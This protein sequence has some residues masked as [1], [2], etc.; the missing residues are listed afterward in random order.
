MQFNK[1][2]VLFKLKMPRT[3][4][5]RKI[6]HEPSTHEIFVCLS[7][8]P[9][10]SKLLVEKKPD[11]AY[12]EFLKWLIAIDFNKD[13]NEKTIL[14]KLAADFKIDTAKAIKW[15]KEI[16][17][18]IFELN[19]EMPVL[20]QKEGIKVC[21][22]LKHY[23]N[24]CYFYTSLPVV[25]RE[26][27]TLSFYFVKG[28]IGIDRFWVKKVE[29]ALEEDKAEITIWLEGGFLNKYR[30]F[31]LDKALF[32]DW[33]GFMDVYDKHS[34]ELDE[35]IKRTTSNNQRVDVPV[36]NTRRYFH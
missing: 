18:D 7:Q 30:E 33:I 4:E 22:Y 11:K 31:A 5:R 24:G 21:L 12:A 17:A 29:Y 36:R 28:I 19:N 2:F 23:D 9:S 10:Y 14:K 6:I 27:E 26:F 16:Y 15:I 32:H 1:N 25:P 13:K 20:F 8:M 34:F 35:L 3:K